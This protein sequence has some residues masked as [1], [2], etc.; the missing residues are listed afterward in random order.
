LKVC[1][2][3][4]S[5]IDP[6]VAWH[7]LQAQIE[8]YDNEGGAAVSDPVWRGLQD[9][10]AAGMD[11]SFVSDMMKSPDHMMRM[12]AVRI[13][14]VR[15]SYITETFDWEAMRAAAI[16]NCEAEKDTITAEYMKNML[17]SDSSKDEDH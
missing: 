9:A 15:S 12:T 11:D 13:L 3:Q 10:L 6:L 4:S 17:S 1:A 14:E 2:C 7:R 5:T 16:R 8:G